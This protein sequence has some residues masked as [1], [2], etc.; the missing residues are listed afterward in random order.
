M[1]YTT[2]DLD[3]IYKQ[4]VQ[5]AMVKYE[6]R[7]PDRLELHGDSIIRAVWTAYRREEDD[8]YIY[9]SMKDLTKDL[10]EVYN[11]RKKE[12]AIAAEK[13]KLDEIRKKHQ[14]D[15]EQ[16]EKR[17]REYEKLKKEFDGIGYVLFV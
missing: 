3:N 1:N 17:K 8:E 16:K 6:G 7:E 9:V 2:E 14:Y 10:E 15:Q 11:E 4:A 5:F 12:E 13:R